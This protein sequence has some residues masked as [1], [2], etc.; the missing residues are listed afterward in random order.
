MV[1]SREWKDDQSREAFDARSDFVSRSKLAD[2]EWTDRFTSLT[3][4][5]VGTLFEGSPG[6]ALLALGSYGRRELCPGS[7]L[8]LM[9]VYSG[10]ENASRISEIADSIWYPIWDRGVGLDHSVKTT[11]QALEVAK[12]DLRAIFGLLDARLVVGDEVLASDLIS[13]TKALWIKEAKHLIPSIRAVLAER[14]EIFGELAFTLEPEIKEAR[15]GLR[16]VNLVRALGYAG[17]AQAGIDEED[18]Q[19]SNELLIAVRV[20]LHKVGMRASDRLLLQDQDQVAGILGYESADTLMRALSEAGRS[21]T[22]SLNEI[23]T[24]LA[25]KSALQRSTSGVVKEEE[26][27]LTFH[28]SQ[29]ELRIQA[30]GQGLVGAGPFL[31]LALI[32][33]RLQLPFSRESLSMLKRRFTSAA[34]PWKPETLDSFLA[35]LQVGRPAIDVIESLD[36]V[37]LLEVLIPEWEVVRCRPQRNA[38]HKYTVDRH[39]LET[40][41]NAVNLR[42]TTNRPDLLIL[43]ALLHDIGKGHEGDHSETGEV[44]ARQI[45]ARMGVRGADQEVV[46]R[47]VRHHLLL[48]DTAMKRDVADSKTIQR[49]AKL[50][51]DEETLYLL[52]TL[53]EADSKATGPLA[54]THWKQVLIAELVSGVERYFKGHPVPSPTSSFDLE[55]EGLELLDGEE[56]QVITRENTV[57]V[58][59]VD[60]LGLFSMVAGTLSVVGMSV[61][62]ADAM[63]HGGLAVERFRVGVA[64][65]GVP[66]WDRFRREL[67]KTL[68]SPETLTERLEARARSL[69]AP[70]KISV[71][72]PL[73]PFVRVEEDASECATVIEVWAPD[74]TG[75][76]Y[77]LTAVFLRFG[78]NIEHAKVMTVG[79]DVVDTFYVVGENGLPLGASLFEELKDALL[80]AATPTK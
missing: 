66:N 4:A 67:A 74:R 71:T 39:L 12:E 53:T 31:E 14:E 10:R 1:I 61:V 24:R 18:L 43:A 37:G 17:L 5:W 22:W 49:V 77:S 32:S 48:A 30:S 76:L 50:V 15:G 6:I 8:D 65:H 41:V 70:R 80:S 38:F 35:L 7:D 46:L 52:A 16:D 33:A 29:G 27:S 56:F 75:L 58:A 42:R 55:M 47:L 23:T 44:I 20:A 54:W 78:I 73:P 40:A 19:R 11:K 63:Q 79:D 9:L 57:Y 13:K 72:E 45:L 2:I 34:I 60:R 59:A 36:R 64:H 21:I 26:L 25:P 3:D 51:V 28:T 69:K 62:A 68:S